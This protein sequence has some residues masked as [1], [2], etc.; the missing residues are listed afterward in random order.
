MNPMKLSTRLIL[1][2]GTVLTVALILTGISLYITRGVAGEARILSNQYMPQT[3]LASEMERSVL[4]A[5]SEMQGYHFSHDVSFLTASRQQ[6]G[7]VKKNLGDAVQLT[8]KYPGLKMLK[9]NA[10]KASV[11]LTEYETL[12]NDTEKAVKEIQGIRKKLEGAAEDFMKACLE[13]LD[14]QTDDLNNELKTGASQVTLTERLRGIRDMEDVI[15]V[16]YVI[17]LETGKGQLLGDPKIIEEAMKKFEEMENGLKAIQK[18]TKKDIAI[19][20]LEDVRMAAANY[21]TNMKKLVTNYAALT[22][23][24]QKRSVAGGGVSDSAKETATAGIG[25]TLKSAANVD[26]LLTDSARILLVGSIIGVFG[27]LVLILFIT[28]GITKPIKRII[29]GLNEGAEQVASGTSQVSSSSQSLAGGASEQAASIEETVSS[30]EEMSSMT[31][32][33]AENA[34]QADAL[35]KEAG[36]VVDHANRSMQQ[37]T[38][39]MEEITRASEET[40]K[41]I[42]TIDEIA[43]QTNLLALNAA[44]EAARAGEVGAGFAVVA[45]EVRNLAMRA[46]DAAK[47]TANLIEGTVKKVKD[48][49][50]L[51]ARSNE[52]F[53]KVAEAASKAAGLIAEI[54]AASKEQSQGIQQVNNAVAEMD[55]VVQQNAANA[56]ENASSSEEM[57]A[58]AQQMR[59]FVD[60]LVLMVEGSR[61]QASSWAHE[62]TSE[63][64]KKTHTRV[65]STVTSEPA[66]AAKE[67]VSLKTGQVNPEEIIPLHDESFKDF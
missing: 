51:V 26:R 63:N 66:R 12:L 42:R 47:N 48:G 36:G 2:F 54:A 15:Q 20:Q 22:D 53:G 7:Q 8:G 32:M 14:D 46:A 50:E 34:R 16:G 4:K 31:Q 64:K 67:L 44:V 43:F 18:K 61:K 40:S 9:D 25:E 60:E 45:D 57:S 38:L 58:Q 35:M 49:S 55:K 62:V 5:I 30:M 23:L 19:S 3:H 41:I 29:V 10:A 6:L 59:E 11:R 1:G 65:E 56:E 17:Q 37:L 21:K 39:S 27:S 13:F 24:G 52:A 33:N 28:R